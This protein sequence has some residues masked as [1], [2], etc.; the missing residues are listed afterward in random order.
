M[1]TCACTTQPTDSPAKLTYLCINTREVLQSH[2]IDILISPQSLFIM[3]QSVLEQPESLMGP[4]SDQ[5]INGQC[6]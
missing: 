3:D 5:P 1:H 2:I 4:Y 6:L